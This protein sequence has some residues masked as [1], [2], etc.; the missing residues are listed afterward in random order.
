MAT[1]INP[2]DGNVLGY[3]EIEAGFQTV[4]APDFITDIALKLTN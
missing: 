3:F 4:I 1:W 2:T